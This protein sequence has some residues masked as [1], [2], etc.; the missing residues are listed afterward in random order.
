MNL[1]QGRRSPALLL[2]HG[3]KQTMDPENPIVKLCVEGMRAEGNGRMEEALALFTQAWQA[4]G[5][6]FERCIAAHYVARHQDTPA[7]MLRWNLEALERARGVGDEQVAGFYP[8]LYLNLGYSYE[9]LGDADEAGRYY[10]LAE[11][12]LGRLGDGRYADVVRSGIV[13]GKDR[14]KET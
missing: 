9:Q 12:M 1:Q 4:A 3:Y 8:S 11:K 14:L 10:D 5:D 7:A 13:R 6:D 2:I